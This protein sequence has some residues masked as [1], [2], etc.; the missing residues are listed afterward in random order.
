M[1]KMNQDE[2]IIKIILSD[3]SIILTGPLQITYR[4]PTP[5]ERYIVV[6]ERRKE[7]RKTYL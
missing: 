2:F 3:L 1:N 4:G 5:E 7:E 6:R